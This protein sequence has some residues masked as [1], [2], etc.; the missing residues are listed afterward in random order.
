[1]GALDCLKRHSPRFLDS[2]TIAGASAGALLGAS[3]VCDVP[4]N[5]VRDGFLRTAI[6]ARKW[7]MGVFTPG[8]KF[9]N[10]LS[11]GLDALPPD[12]HIKASGRLYVSVTRVHDMTNVIFSE[13]ESREDLIQT[14][15]CSCFILG[16]SGLYPPILHGVK[17]MDGGYTNKQP[18]LG[19][20]TVTVSPY[21]GCADISPKENEGLG[22]LKWANYG[23]N[24]SYANV[25][26]LYRTLMPPPPYILNHYY[27]YGYEDAF[28]FLRINR[29]CKQ[30]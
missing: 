18:E 14:L 1:M 12:A 13:W 4:L 23:M 27:H 19:P 20:N 26:R 16:F 7:K 5:G 22:Q 28:Q 10:Y 2:A 29:K 17:Y 24:I 9:E 21:S 25:L 6:E 15:R 3:I 11:A 8:F 30:R